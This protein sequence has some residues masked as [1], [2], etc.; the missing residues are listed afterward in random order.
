MASAASLRIARRV[1][2][3]APR[4]PAGW[5]HVGYAICLPG[6]R[7]DVLRGGAARRR[8]GRRAAVL[9]H[10]PGRSRRGARRHGGAGRGPDRE[11]GRGRGHRDPRRPGHR[12]RPGHPGG[13]ADP[14]RVRAA[15]QA[16]D[17]ARRHQA[18]R[19]PP[20]VHAAVPRLARRQ[21]A[22]R[23]VGAAGVQRRGGPSGR[24]RPGGRRAGRRLRRRP[25]RPGRHRPRCARP[26]QRRDQVRRGVTARAAA[27]AHRRGPHARWPRSWPK[28]T[29]A[30]CSRS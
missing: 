30:R 24:G 26:G 3:S 27:R 20:A 4:T 29:R 28:T 5:H 9:P 1:R 2:G 14:H 8:P 11:L 23:R 15:G 12:E 21:P 22:G 13:T 16:G 19:R 10:H 7:G 17:R 6:A 18:D 25:V